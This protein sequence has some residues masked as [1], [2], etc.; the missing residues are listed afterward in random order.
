MK[1]KFYFKQKLFLNKIYYREQNYEKY[2]IKNSGRILQKT[3]QRTTFA[4]LCRSH[5]CT[6][7]SPKD[8]VNQA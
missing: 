6:A 5:G 3:I 2:Y 8:E 7:L 4:A 1:T